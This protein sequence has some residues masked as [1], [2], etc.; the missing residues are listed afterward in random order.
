MMLRGGVARSHL[1]GLIGLIMAVELSANYCRLLSEI[2]HEDHSVFLMT[3]HVLQV[4]YTQKVQAPGDLYER[5][6]LVISDSSDCLQML[7][8][9][10]LSYQFEDE[11]I[12]L[13]SLVKVMRV[14]IGSMGR[15]G[16]YV[17][18]LQYPAPVHPSLFMSRVYVI[19]GLKLYEKHASLYGS[20][21][22][23]VPYSSPAGHVQSTSSNG[24]D[25]HRSFNMPESLPARQPVASTERADPSPQSLSSASRSSGAS[26]RVMPEQTHAGPSVVHTRLG[27]TLPTV[28]PASFAAHEADASL[29]QGA[30]ASAGIPLPDD[31]VR[32]EDLNPFMSHWTIRATVQQ[33]SGLGTLRSG[34]GHWFNAVFKDD[35]GSIKAVAFGDAA[36]AH[37]PKLEQGK[38]YDIS[39]A[40]I[41]KPDPKFR[42]NHDYELSLHAGTQIVEVID[43]LIHKEDSINVEKQCQGQVDIPRTFVDFSAIPKLKAADCGKFPSRGG[44]RPMLIVACRRSMRSDRRRGREERHY[45]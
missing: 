29:P 2:G 15:L 41:K 17:Q 6:L 37:Y 16:R 22:P 7:L 18:S 40:S 13:G 5:Y 20:P 24:L 26:N 12:I 27:L 23:L 32:I 21:A 3:E 10:K 25:A 28:P 31:L 35:T 14:T 33:K 36:S 43:I 42:S 11:N 19:H 30:T 34:S 8:S 39:K 44:H 1:H 9:P 45:T 38:V 4:L